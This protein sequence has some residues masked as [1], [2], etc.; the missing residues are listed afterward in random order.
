MKAGRRQSARRTLIDQSART[1]RICTIDGFTDCVTRERVLWLGDAYMDCLGTYY[2]EP[3]RGLVLDTIYQHAYSQM[4]NGS[5]RAY[6]SSDLAPDWILMTSYNMLWLNMLCDYALYSGDTDSIRP[7]LPTAKRLIDYL[8]SQRNEDGVIDTDNGGDGFWDWGFAED[9][10]LL[11]MSNAYFIHTVERLHAHPFFSSL[12]SEK[13]YSEIGELRRKCFE[14]FYDPESG[15]FFDAVRPDGEGSLRSQTANCL[16]IMSGICYYD[17]TN[18]E[19]VLF[20]ECDPWHA[21]TTMDERYFVYDVK[22]LERYGGK[23]YRGCPAAVK[24]LNRETGK[25]INIVTEMPEGGTPEKPNGYHIDPHPRFTEN[26]KYI[27]FTTTE[28]GSVDLAVA[29]VDELIELSK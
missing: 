14:I 25:L 10:G 27:V 15:T 19:H 20:H 7:L 28:L 11:L 23:W 26:E 12:I 8:C 3:D 24:F 4:P 21:H 5:L 16:A 17:I 13:L 2:S 22:M 1:Q 6:T 18:G 9:E 29:Y